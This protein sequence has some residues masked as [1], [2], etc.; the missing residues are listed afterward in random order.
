MLRRLQALVLATI[1]VV[2]AF[3]TGY[4]FLFYLH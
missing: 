3:S 2:A 1:L 4:T